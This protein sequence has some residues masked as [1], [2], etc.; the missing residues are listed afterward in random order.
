MDLYADAS[1]LAILLDLWPTPLHLP[2]TLDFKSIVKTESFSQQYK[3]N[4]VNCQQEILV[5][6]RAWE[7]GGGINMDGCGGERERHGEDG[8]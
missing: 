2:S 3:R 1:C 6:H 4:T 5:W 7:L 8:E